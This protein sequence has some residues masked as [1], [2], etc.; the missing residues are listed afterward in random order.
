[1]AVKAVE[2]VRKIRDRN[3]EAT[4]KLTKNNKSNLSEERLNCCTKKLLKSSRWKKRA[5]LQRPRPK[6]SSLGPPLRVSN[7]DSHK[8]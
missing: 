2:M 8:R 4:R 3:F 6:E 1:M 5:K 7:S